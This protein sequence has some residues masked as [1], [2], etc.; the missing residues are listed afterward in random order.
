MQKTGRLASLTVKGMG[1]E[2]FLV[3]PV[4]TE[5]DGFSLLDLSSALEKSRV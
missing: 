5:V 1:I 3:L 4:L 2:N